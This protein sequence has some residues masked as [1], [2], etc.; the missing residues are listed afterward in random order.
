MAAVAW[1][2]ANA[3]KTTHVVRGKQANGWNLYDTLGNV[4]EWVADLYGKDYYREK[5]GKD[6]K[7]PKGP[8]FGE[9]RVLRGWSYLEN[10]VAV[11]VSDRNWNEPPMI[12]TSNIGFRCAGELP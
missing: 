6:P 9:K 1:Y 3:A 7:G 10:P 11:R 5:E 8:R 2:A 4:W 12:R